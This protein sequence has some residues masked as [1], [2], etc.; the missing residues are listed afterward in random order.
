MY[1]I[2]RRKG[3]KRRYDSYFRLSTPRSGQEKSQT[4]SVPANWLEGPRR[5]VVSRTSPRV[6]GRRCH[7]TIVFS[8]P[9]LSVPE[10]SSDGKWLLLVL[11]AVMSRSQRVDS[12][13]LLHWLYEGPH[14]PSGG[15][16]GSNARVVTI[17]CALSRVEEA[18]STVLESWT[19]S[20]LS[21]IQRNG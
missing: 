8:W 17:R 9:P 19:E 13:P 12:L 7:V 14:N 21:R 16:W 1:K 15:H 2:T 20:G 4:S 11:R 5:A 3:R 6:Y 10:R 18:E